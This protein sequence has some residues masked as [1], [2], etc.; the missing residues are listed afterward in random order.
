MSG[1][2]KQQEELPQNFKYAL[3]G[4]LLILKILL[5]LAGP[6]ADALRASTDSPVRITLLCWTRGLSPLSYHRVVPTCPSGRYA[7]GLRKQQE[8]FTPKSR[9]Y[10]MDCLPFPETLRLILLFP[11]GTRTILAGP[12][13]FSGDKSRSCQPYFHTTGLPCFWSAV[14][15]YRFASATSVDVLRK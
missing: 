11:A 2:R 12:P 1:L 8:N 7:P 13:A 15:Q 5:S 9:L 10:L 6:P 4:P 14:L 3:P